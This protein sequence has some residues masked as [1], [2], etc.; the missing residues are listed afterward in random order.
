MRRTS[1][2][3]LLLPPLLVLLAAAAACSNS[4]ERDAAMTQ[5]VK[6]LLDADRNVDTT[7]LAVSTRD[8]VVTLEGEVRDDLARR[9]AVD[10]AWQVV[11]VT[12]VVDQLRT[13]R[14]ALPADPPPAVQ[15]AVRAAL[16]RPAEKKAGPVGHV[17]AAAVA[18]VVIPP[19][20]NEIDL[21]VVE[22]TATAD[23]VSSRPAPVE[24]AEAPEAE[25][26]DGGDFPDPPATRQD[27]GSEAT[28]EDAAITLQVRAKIE[29]AVPSGRVQ[30]ATRRGVVTLSGAVDTELEKSHALKAAREARGVE[31]VVDHIVVLR[32]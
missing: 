6:S 31:R 10:I 4:A 2:S 30:V 28:A 12:R 25:E 29:E 23:R 16:S 1:L 5:R 24:A 19:A 9:R 17:V 15:R 11:G 27:P 21:T 32:S 3:A 26:P 7:Q 8:G 20:Q 14:V 13:A 18:P 22:A